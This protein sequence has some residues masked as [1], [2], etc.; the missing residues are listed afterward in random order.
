MPMNV[1]PDDRNLV[2]GADLGHETHLVMLR[3]PLGEFCKRGIV[4]I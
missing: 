4:L 2:D 1:V 3:D